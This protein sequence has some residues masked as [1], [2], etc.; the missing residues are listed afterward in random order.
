MKKNDSPVKT[1][2]AP[3]K[4]DEKEKQPI[5]DE[6]LAL[7][8]K[9]PQKGKIGKE[10]TV[11]TNSFVVRTPLDQIHLHL[12]EFTP[13]IPEDAKDQRLSAINNKSVRD[14]IINTY[15][16]YFFE[17]KHLLCLRKKEAENQFTNEDLTQTITVKYLKS[18]DLNDLTSQHINQHE[19]IIH[20]MLN[21]V[22]RGSDLVRIGQNYFE[23]NESLFS[24]KG[25]FDIRERGCPDIRIWR[26]YSISCER[27][28]GG[29]HMNVD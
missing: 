27:K 25:L 6:K 9:R 24:G 7:V 16:P 22:I 10:V 14:K 2:D 12:I 8:A 4:V 5:I 1:K 20:L 23:R 11:I 13:D 19:Q 18:I 28:T 29:I 15:G 21:K 17:N 26:G 3:K